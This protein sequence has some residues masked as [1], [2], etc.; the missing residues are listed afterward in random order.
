M[1]TQNFTVEAMDTP[2]VDRDDGGHI[3][4]TPK[5]KVLNRQLL[6]PKLAI[7][8]MKLSVL[9]G[10]AFATAMNKRGV[11]IG[12]INYQD[13]GNWAV[14]T[15]EGPHVH[16]HLFGRAKSAKI[17]KY[18]EFCYLPPRSKNPE[19]YANLK[20]LNNGDIA[21]IKNEID[22]LLQTE[23]YKDATWGL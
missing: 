21:E 1:E 7:E 5:I 19:F 14:H 17:Q 8:F 13:M 4:I 22:N 9:V 23:K 15:P 10:E 16:N 18:D 12:R 3:K 6:S 2:F 11:D 20:P